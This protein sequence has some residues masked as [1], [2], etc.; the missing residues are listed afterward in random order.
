[1]SEL[2]DIE[3]LSKIDKPVL[4]DPRIMDGTCNSNK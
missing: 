1:M 2:L 4:F 3:N